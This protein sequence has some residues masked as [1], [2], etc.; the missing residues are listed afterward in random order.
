M[1]SVEQPVPQKSEIHRNPPKEIFPYGESGMKNEQEP[2]RKKR[3]GLAKELTPK[4]KELLS[5]LTEEIID[6]IERVIIREGIKRGFQHDGFQSL[7]EK[8]RSEARQFLEEKLYPEILPKKE[9]RGI[10]LPKND[11][12]IHVEEWANEKNNTDH[13][14]PNLSNK[15]MKDIILMLADHFIQDMKI[16]GVRDFKSYLSYRA[17][18]DSSSKMTKQ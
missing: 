16:E 9:L 14:N 5:R 13:P 1:S 8:V 3:F 18:H 2:I 11:Q 6:E 7:F 12:E 10:T 17:M 15:I 4:A